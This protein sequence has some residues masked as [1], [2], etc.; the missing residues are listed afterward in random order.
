[1]E[2]SSQLSRSLRF[3]GVNVLTAVGRQRNTHELSPET[4]ATLKNREPI[5]TTVYLK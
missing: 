3:S 1:M 2:T 5:I 4:A